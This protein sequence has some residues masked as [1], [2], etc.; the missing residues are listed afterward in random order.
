M[1][2]P[3]CGKE[4]NPGDKFCIACGTK[5]ESSTAGGQTGAGN[6]AGPLDN[7]S[8]AGAAERAN[9]MDSN[10]PE[11]NI[12]EAINHSIQD[13]SN[14]KMVGGTKSMIRRYFLGYSDLLWFAVLMYV[15]F[16]VAKLVYTWFFGNYMIFSSSQSP[17]IIFCNVM[18]WVAIIIFIGALGISIYV[19]A[20]GIGKNYVDTATQNAIVMLKARTQNKFNVDSEQIEEVAP[21]LVIGSGKSPAEDENK[22]SKLHKYIA[23]TVKVFTKDPVEGYRIGNDGVSRYLLISATLYAFTD[24]QL[25]VYSGNVDIATGMVYDESVSEIFYRDINSVTQEDELKTVKA[26]LFKK[27]YYALKSVQFDVCGI[28]KKAAFDSRFVQNAETSLKG[29]ESYIREKKF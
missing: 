20:T 17:F 1:N 11:T 18:Q 24:T 12:S 16:Q 2:C 29:M 22:K 6:G 15:L 14:G 10:R 9:L 26:G 7:E 27:K 23:K 21:I 13:I 28:Q 25:L 8:I 19:K 3:N 5:I 4:L